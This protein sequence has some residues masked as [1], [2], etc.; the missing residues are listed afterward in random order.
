MKEAVNDFIMPRRAALNT[1]RPD[2][3]AGYQDSSHGVCQL[4]I[5]Q[6]RSSN[7]NSLWRRTLAE[8]TQVT[9][10][11]QTHGWRTDS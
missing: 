7:A 3:L 2:W 10:I 11:S 8:P 5:P 1:W 9:T 6:R 4:R